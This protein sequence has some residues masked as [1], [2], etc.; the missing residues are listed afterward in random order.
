MSVLRTA[1]ER[2][3]LLGFGTARRLFL[4]QG[5]SFGV[6]WLATGS[7]APADAPP[8]LRDAMLS[9]LA[10]SLTCF[11]AGVLLIAARRWRA[12][13]PTGTAPE[14]AWPWPLLVGISLIVCSALAVQAGAQL[15]A[16]WGEIG[17][18][19]EAIGFWQAFGQP[20]G[21]GIVLLATLLALSVPAV[22]TTAA[23]SQLALPLLL[24]PLLALRS[25]LFPTLLAMTVVCQG[26]LVL[27]SGI[28]TAA[29]ARL[30]A[31]FNAAMNASGDA[32][33]QQVSEQLERWSGVLGEAANALVLPL[34]VLLAWLPF[35][36]PRSAAAAWF[37]RGA[38]AGAAPPPPHA[39]TA[40][41]SVAWERIPWK[42]ATPSASAPTAPSRPGRARSAP[43]P[44]LPPRGVRLGLSMMGA[45]LLLFGACDA[46]RTRPT[47][48]HSQPSP[49][50]RLD[51]PPAAVRVSF[52][53][54]LH[55][56]SSLSLTRL[57]L[58]PYIG[59]SP[60][61][62]ELRRGLAPDDAERRTLEGV[63]TTL[64]PG[65]YRVSWMALPAG[66]GVPRHGSFSFGVGIDVPADEPGLTHSLVDRDSGERGRRKT[67][68]GGALLLALGLML[69]LFGPRR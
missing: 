10:L 25:R 14:A 8:W 30:L 53:A 23:L 17:A 19:L 46:L 57:V 60:T 15:P 55:P 37:T 21:G 61:P 44:Q 33:V 64:A 62:I 67:F 2:L 6:A 24:L 26:A 31:E 13:D 49:G 39:S 11:V 40:P 50:A 69:P 7:L 51:A 45:A 34:L 27:G 43:A 42:P 16:L 58:P 22:V 3:L 18:R 20:G 12:P 66:G 59:E 47:Y 1:L 28:A 38:R 54:A 29:E 48:V 4:F 36:R 35:L 68:A 5:V 63:P 52:G 65:V 41:A 9:A 32:E 56:D